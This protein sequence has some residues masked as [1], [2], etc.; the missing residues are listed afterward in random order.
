M[1]ADVFALGTMVAVLA[2]LAVEWKSSV[3]GKWIAK[4][5]ASTGFLL[6]AV[7][8]GCFDSTYGLWVFIGLALSFLG[9]VFLIPKAKASFLAGL[10]FFLLGH[11]AYIVAFVVRGQDWA[12]TGGALVVLVVLAV[13]VG[14][15]LLPHVGSMRVPVLAYIA[16]IT[17]MITTAAGTYAYSAHN[18]LLGGALMFYLSDLSVARDRFI[19]D[20]FAN[21]I[22]GLPLYY[23]GQILLALSVAQ[24]L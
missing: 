13:V 11:V 5:L 8:S 12:S 14:R 1:K 9:D 2:L 6:T 4:P 21:R 7:A 22:W 24:Q 16:V 23:G 18:L 19:K 3:K 17:L 15:W 20:V 10:V